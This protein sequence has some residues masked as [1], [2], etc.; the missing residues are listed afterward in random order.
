M[1]RI[2]TMTLLLAAVW[3]SQT[4]ADEPKW[5]KHDVNAKSEFEAAGVLDVNNDGKLDIVSG[6]TWYEAPN[7]SPHKVREVPPLPPAGTLRSTS[8]P[9]QM[10]V[11]C[12]YSAR[13]WAGWKTRAKP[14]SSDF[15]PIESL[16]RAGGR[17]GRPDRRQQPEVLPT[18]SPTCLVRAAR[19]RGRATE[20]A[21]LWR[22]RRLVTESA[23]RR[24]R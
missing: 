24:Q 1:V 12:S 2:P 4:L 17:H 14:A 10:D 15:S 13:T 16:G 18:W 11:T 20:E 7:W 23:G 6:D 21:R 8:M 22:G 9:R 19:R 5:K 3:C